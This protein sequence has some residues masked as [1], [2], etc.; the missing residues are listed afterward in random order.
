MD[1]R[2]S[3]L[4]NTLHAQG[5]QLQDIENLLKQLVGGGTAYPPPQAV[6]EPGPPNG[7]SGT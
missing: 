4:E 5:L 7:G 3:T 6:T 2:V 1:S